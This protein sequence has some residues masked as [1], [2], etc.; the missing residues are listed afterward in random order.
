MTELADLP[1]PTDHE[2]FYA[3]FT[4]RNGGLI[5]EGWQQRL[6]ETRFVVA[7][8]GSTGG[9][10]VMPLVRSGAEHFVLLDP[11]RYELNNLNRQ[12]ADLKDLGVNKAAATRARI[13]AVN[14]FA[15]VQVFEDG[16]AA[17]TI[18]ERLRAGDVVVDA[19]DVTTDAGVYAKYALHSAAC[20]LRLK[21]LTAYDIAAA[22]YVEMF[23]YEE[24]RE[25][26]GG[27]VSEPFTSK[28][29]LRALVPPRALPREI[30]AEL[31]A[32]RSDARRGFPQ[33]AMTSTLFG[34]IAV[35]YLLRAINGQPVR[36]R[37]RI[38]LYDETRPVGA[39]LLERLRRDVDLV[40][41]WWKLR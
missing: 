40:G 26:L 38:D 14:P 31:L 8:C 18:A 2:A 12:D 20:E 6:R 13:L 4:E 15:D 34:S 39:R 16:V 29:V 36:R 28:R 33:L 17:P 3:T 7:G 41:L 23:D 24:V 35:A 5:S 37:V 9:A 22:Q 10:C 19:V 21:V 27:R 30:F 32:R 1:V 11:G 25:P